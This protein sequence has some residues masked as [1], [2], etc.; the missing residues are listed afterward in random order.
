MLHYVSKL[1]TST[2]VI[3]VF[4]TVLSVLLFLTGFLASLGMILSPKQDL[5]AMIFVIVIMVTS[6]FMFKI[7]GWNIRKYFI[8]DDR[9]EIHI[10]WGVKKIVY[11]REAL[12][13]FNDLKVL[14]LNE[15]GGIGL[16]TTEGK[17]MK[18][19]ELE[20]DEFPIFV[21]QL[22]RIVRWDL[23]LK[24]KEIGGYAQ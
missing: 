19:L 17:M 20:L 10:L 6:F 3:R 14:V 16:V 2:V 22:Q 12:K 21:E 11:P 7:S 4:I 13:A 5:T 9:L 1:K 8:Y 23:T 15:S 24:F 18:I